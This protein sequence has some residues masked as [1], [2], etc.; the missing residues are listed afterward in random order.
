MKVVFMYADNEEEYNCTHWRSYLPST[1]LQR[2][3]KWDTVMHHI[4]SIESPETQESLDG[5]DI[6]FVER[7]LSSSIFSRLDILRA[8]TG[9]KI[10]FDMD[11]A[12]KFMEPGSPSYNFWINGIVPS[13]KAGTKM[14]FP[15]IEQIGWYSKNVDAISSPSKLLLEDWKDFNDRLL[16]LPNFA[17]ADLYT[18]IP[19]REKDKV[20]IGWG[21]GA[22]HYASWYASGLLTAFRRVYER[23]KKEIK[24]SLVTGDK[25]LA[26]K[27]KEFNPD[28]VRSDRLLYPQEISKFD[29]ALAPVHGEYD[30]RRSWLKI[31]EYSLSGIPWIGS[32]LDPYREYN[33][34]GSV[35]VRNRPKDWEDALEEMIKNRVEYYSKVKNEGYALWK[36]AFSIQD[37]HEFLANQFKSVTERAE[38]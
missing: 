37:N 2:F 26:Y 31:S 3:A 34:P 16:W 18:I 1:F 28:V 32:D 29:I 10:I 6:V 25:Q 5:A 30:R 24:L 9:A 27:L 38:T 17:D 4:R 15:P 11:D 22:T 7:L 19:Y 12:Y 36:K 35:L 13:G 20:V 14:S 23:H 33:Y 21:G 8:T